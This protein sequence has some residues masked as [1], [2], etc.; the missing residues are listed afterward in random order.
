MREGIFIM[1]YL[2]CINFVLDIL[3]R[4]LILF[5]LNFMGIVVG[6]LIFFI[7]MNKLRF[8]VVKLFKII[9]EVIRL[10]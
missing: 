6:F 10:D 3:R 7:Y 1:V 5:Y 9:C 8:V 2:L 4:F